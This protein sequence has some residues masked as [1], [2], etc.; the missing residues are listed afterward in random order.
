MSQ[1]NALMQL[2]A[3]IAGGDLSKGLSAAGMAATKGTQDAR[4]IAVRQRLVNTTLGDRTWIGSRK[5]VSL[6]AVL[7]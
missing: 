4:K 5:K 3:G 1:A 2:G 6:A 7:R